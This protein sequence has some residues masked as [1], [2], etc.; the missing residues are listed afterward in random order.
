[1]FLGNRV[2][3]TG[4]AAVMVGLLI[5]SLMLELNTEQRVKDVKVLAT[6]QARKADVAQYLRLMVDAETSQRGFLLTQD[7]DYLNQY[8]DARKQAPEL[9][10]RISNSYLFEDSKPPSDAIRADLDR[11]RQL[12]NA[13]MDELSESLTL[14]DANQREEALQVV[15]TN[16]GKRTMDA[17]RRI[18]ADLDEQETAR[19]SVAL[20]QWEAGTVVWRAMLVGGTLL[21]IALVI[22]VAYL[23]NRDLQR[24]EASAQDLERH[25]QQL[26]HLV[27][28]RTIELSALSS[29]LQNVAE[30]EKAA[31]ARELHDELGGIMLAA[32]MD[33]AWLEK[34]LSRADD[35]LKVRWSRLRKLLDDGL[36]LKRRV[37]ETLGP[38]LLD[39]MG[40]VPAVKWLCQETCAR[41]G[42]KCHQSYPDKDLRLDDEAAIAV[43]RVIQEALANIVKHA[44]ATEVELMILLDDESLKICIRDNGVGIST[45]R[46]ARAGQGLASMQHRVISFGGEWRVSTPD[47]GGTAI[48]IALPL[49]RIAT[50][51]AVAIA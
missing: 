35:E 44:K 6:A 41:A 21:N 12:G 20:A 43:F 32:K 7:L 19:I 49:R 29:H 30:R 31:I 16:F 18:A 33:V 27:D 42:L 39:N 14:A 3:L 28:R 13:K 47:N 45:R 51:P 15:R 24:R 9:L 2:Y 26:A 5:A 17:L 1:M 36:N 8:V 40:L 23:L 25:T 48:D 22:V 4:I 37:V 38:T 11:L 50:S 34:R 10:D 46:S